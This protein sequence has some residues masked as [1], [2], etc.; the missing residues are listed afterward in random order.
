MDKN[1]VAVID[2][3]DMKVMAKWS[4]A[5]A[6]QPVAMSMDANGKLLFV[7]C[8]SKQIAVM[9]ARDGHILAELP[10]GAG[11]DATAFLRGT[12]FASCGDGTLTVIQETPPG[13][14]S[15]VQTVKTALRAKTMAVDRNTG[16]IYLPT[17][18]GPRTS[19]VPSSFKVLVV[20]KSR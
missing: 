14:F 17:A 2:T 7:G 6:A 4:V 18:D 3:K 1:E 11:V 9:S 5:S 16:T 12:A 13:K 10:I 8:R 20:S 19:Q 15:V